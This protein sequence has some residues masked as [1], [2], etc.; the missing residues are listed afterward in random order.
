MPTKTLTKVSLTQWAQTRGQPPQPL[1]LLLAPPPTLSRARGPAMMPVFAASGVWAAAPS[2]GWIWG[3]ETGDRGTPQ[4]RTEALVTT[5][6]QSVAT[7]ATTTFGS[8]QRALVCIDRHAQTGG[9]LL[10]GQALWLIYLAGWQSNLATC[11][12]QTQM[13]N[14]S[15]PQDQCKDIMQWGRVLRPSTKINNLLLTE[16]D[17]WSESL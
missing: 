12:S 7:T 10:A 4:R 1:W 15:S 13:V 6:Y 9:F 11:R 14:T 8:S 17:L 3:G 2:R 16:L 5:G